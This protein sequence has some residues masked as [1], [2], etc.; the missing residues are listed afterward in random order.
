[1]PGPVAI[2]AFMPPRCNC[3]TNLCKGDGGSMKSID[4]DG[5]LTCLT[6][7]VDVLLEI[8]LRERGRAKKGGDKRRGVELCVKTKC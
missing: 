5:P 7:Q 6:G 3:V 8:R 2:L 4:W 1:M